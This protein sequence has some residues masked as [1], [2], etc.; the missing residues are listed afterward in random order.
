M[1][2]GGSATGGIGGMFYF[3]L[4][5]VAL[6]GRY[7]RQATRKHESAKIIMP[8]VLVAVFG[9]L[10]ILNL[11]GNHVI[12]VGS[13]ISNLVKGVETQTAALQTSAH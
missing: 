6:A 3:I 2:A 9:I 5:L 8:A 11:Q 13:A 1:A 10:V 12:D 4:M 7:H